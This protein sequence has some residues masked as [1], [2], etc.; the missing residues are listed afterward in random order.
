MKDSET[1]LPLVSDGRVRSFHL[2]HT[3]AGFT[4]RGAVCLDPVQTFVSNSFNQLLIEGFLQI[5]QMT[6]LN[7]PLYFRESV[8]IDTFPLH[9]FLVI[10]P[11]NC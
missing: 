7:S 1:P 9:S 2:M 11:D 8:Y 6:F 3:T 4:G 5:P 10:F